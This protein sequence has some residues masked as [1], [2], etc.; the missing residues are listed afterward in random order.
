MLNLVL[1]VVQ[2]HVVVR[3]H[4]DVVVDMERLLLWGI[5][6]NRRDHIYDASV[7]RIDVYVVVLLRLGLVL[8]LVCSKHG[9]HFY[10][11]RMR[12]GGL[13]RSRGAGP[14]CV[15]LEQILR[16]ILSDLD[17]VRDG[18]ATSTLA[19]TTQQSVP[20]SGIVGAVDE[21]HLLRSLLVLLAEIIS[22]FDKLGIVLA[23]HEVS[24]T[25]LGSLGS[26]TAVGEDDATG[27]GTNVVLATKQ[28]Q[29]PKRDDTRLFIVVIRV[30]LRRVAVRV[31][32]FLGVLL[33]RV[34]TIG[35]FDAFPDTLAV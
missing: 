35:R 16:N 25:S 30:A 2:V 13:L 4:V 3:V 23:L 6:L 24:R 15:D 7:N 19:P 22:I 14:G 32:G 29:A 31:G 12:R 28:G 9:V 1:V 11:K 18:L 27:I 8:S 10:F 26:N 33:R 20:Q 21:A 17:S 34:A 5:V